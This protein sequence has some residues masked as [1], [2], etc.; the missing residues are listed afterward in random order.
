MPSATTR[1]IARQFGISKDVVQRHRTSHLG[2]ALVRIAAAREDLGAE[3]ILDQ[4]ADLQART[5]SALARVEADAE[6]RP[7]DVGRLV[8][9]VRENALA[10]A[11]LCGVLKSDGRVSTIVDN[12]QQIAI[13]VFGSLT[14]DELRSLVRLAP[15][16]EVPV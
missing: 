14:T 16:A 5:L 7:A 10:T 6:G 2:P 13:S 9:E 3:T 8:R 15:P 11:R 12:R 1:D 4:L